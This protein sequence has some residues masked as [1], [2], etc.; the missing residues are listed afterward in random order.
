MLSL[1]ISEVLISEISS[2]QP[3]LK[4]WFYNC[5]KLVYRLPTLHKN[6][7]I[8]FDIRVKLIICSM[9]ISLIKVN[10][11]KNGQILKKCVN[12]HIS[13][14]KSNIQPNSKASGQTNTF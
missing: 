7:H 8:P 10:H 3:K 2:K 13:M 6:V 1:F 11:L 4:L 12:G 14:S 9:F 5:V